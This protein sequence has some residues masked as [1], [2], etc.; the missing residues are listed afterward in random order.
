MVFLELGQQVIV[1]HL[2][3]EVAEQH[4]H[5]VKL[6]A[7]AHLIDVPTELVG[8]IES[9]HGFLTFAFIDPAKPLTAK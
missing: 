5:D 9:V 6:L 8:V 1:V 4:C 2:L 3:A 7:S